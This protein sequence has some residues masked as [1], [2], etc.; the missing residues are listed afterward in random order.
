MG[1]EAMTSYATKNL[2]V[3]DNLVQFVLHDTRMEDASAYYKASKP[4]VEDYER[5]CGDL[6]DVIEQWPLS[7]NTEW[8]GQYIK[9]I[10]SNT[11]KRRAC[12]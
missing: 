2:G 6:E 10:L 9:Q 12:E 1:N 3:D 11:Y 5:I 7:A 8:C 4:I